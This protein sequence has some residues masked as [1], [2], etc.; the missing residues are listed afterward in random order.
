MQGDPAAGQL[1][2]MLLDLLG[3]LLLLDRLLRLLFQQQSFECL[4]LFY[5]PLLLAFVSLFS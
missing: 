5:E 1:L 3:Q 4:G 2:S